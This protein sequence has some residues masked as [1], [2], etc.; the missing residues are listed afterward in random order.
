MVVLFD[1]HIHVIFEKSPEWQGLKHFLYIPCLFRHNL[2]I[3]LQNL[4]GPL[5][6][7]K[8][9]LA[10]AVTTFVKDILRSVHYPQ[11]PGVT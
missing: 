3:N 1:S 11:F 5:S 9:F 7:G 10:A 8:T 6:G 4:L 2:C